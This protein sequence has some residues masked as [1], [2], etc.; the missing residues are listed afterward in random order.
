MFYVGNPSPSAATVVESDSPRFAVG[1]QAIQYSSDGGHRVFMPLQH[2]RH[3]FVNPVTHVARTQGA[4]RVHQDHAA[5]FGET[6]L[7]SFALAIDQFQQFITYHC[8]PKQVSEASD[9]L[10]YSADAAHHFGPLLQKLT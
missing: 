7:P 10:F 2:G 3:S 8:I 5:G 6:R 9:G 1:D 4:V